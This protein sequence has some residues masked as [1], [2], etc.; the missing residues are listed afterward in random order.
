MKQDGHQ[1]YHRPL[2]KKCF[3]II[4]IFKSGISQAKMFLLIKMAAKYGIG[5]WGIF[6]L[7]Y[8]YIYDRDITS[9]YVFMEK[10]GHQI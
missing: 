2:W 8:S 1:I 10:D 7:N 5:H 3:K 9:E 4:L 6:F